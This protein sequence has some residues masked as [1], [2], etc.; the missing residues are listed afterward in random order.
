MYF[1]G[2][3]DV[4]LLRR[5]T[6]YVQSDN[7]FFFLSDILQDSSPSV[8]ESGKTRNG[9][10]YWLWNRG[11]WGLRKYC[12]YATNERVPSLV[13]SLGSLT[14]EEIFCPAFAALVSPVQIFFAPHYFSS[15]VPIAQQARQAVVPGRLSLN[16]PLGNWAKPCT[17]GNG[18]KL[19]TVSVGEAHV[20]L[21]Q[22]S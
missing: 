16:V 6:I 12:R 2:V 21:V 19:G 14:V 9:W 7:V 5:N 13:G 3:E 20:G 10:P 8:K 1:A 17:C 15:F 22:L 4:P 18:A 11:K